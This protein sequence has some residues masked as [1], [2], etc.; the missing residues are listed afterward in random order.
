LNSCPEIFK[1]LLLG[2]GYSHKVLTFG[3][4]EEQFSFGHC[5]RLG[6]KTYLQLVATG[7]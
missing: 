7:S 3:Q 1:D 5:W 2:L 6:V 4:S